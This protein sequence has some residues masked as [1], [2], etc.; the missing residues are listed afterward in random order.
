MGLVKS[1][2]DRVLF[3]TAA[4][5]PDRVA[6]R[7]GKSKEIAVGRYPD[8]MAAIVAVREA[9]RNILESSGVPAGM[10]GAYYAFVSKLVKYAYSHSGQSLEKIKTGLKAWYVAKGCDPQILDKLTVLV[11]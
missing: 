5:G 8:A 6:D 10:Q 2:N 3:F 7:Y 9:V 1:L 11:A 4:M